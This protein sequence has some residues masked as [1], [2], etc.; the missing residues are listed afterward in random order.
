MSEHA[1]SFYEFLKN[2]KY[3]EAIKILKEHAEIIH[4]RTPFI[5]GGQAGDADDFKGKTHSILTAA[6]NEGDLKVVV[7]C[8]SAGADVY[9]RGMFGET[10]LHT[11]CWYGYHEIAKLLVDKGAPLEVSDAQNNGT[12]ITWAVAGGTKDAWCGKSYHVE[13]IDLLYS[14]GAVLSNDTIKRIRGAGGPFT[15]E[16]ETF[17]KE[18]KFDI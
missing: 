5:F 1:E 7:E 4:I 16:V 11:A 14:K 12:P 13:C 17:F 10:P 15:K 8:L 18:N 2:K 9:E 3:L 6:V